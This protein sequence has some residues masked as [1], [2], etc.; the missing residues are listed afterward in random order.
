MHPSD[1]PDIRAKEL[2]TVIALAEYGSFVAAAAYLKTSQPALTRTIKR[3]E[4]VLGVTLFARNTRRVE[5]TSAGR[6]FVAVAERILNDLQLTVRSMSEV[7]NE[8]RGKITI[9]TFS[10]FATHTMPDLVRQYRETR[11]SMEVRIREGRQSEIVEDVRTGVA[12]FG[13]GYVNTLPDILQSDMLRREPLYAVIPLSHPMGAKRRPRVRL[14]ELRDEALVSPPSETYL[15]RLIDGAAAAAG[16]S[17]R[18]SVTVERLLSVINHVRA[19]VGIGILP[20]G[21][22]PH[23]PWVGIH[24]AILVEPSLSVSVGLIT[25]RGR[26]LTPAASS[27]MALISGE[28]GGA[29]KT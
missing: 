1:V 29:A 6:E 5:I 25:S 15:R 2:L 18:Y 20:A 27:M 10:A 17:P 13:I 4:R 9:S 21:V 14:A 8:Q 22:L 19:G 28:I 12:D 24:A 11:P 26:Y 23:Q 3:V 7:T 16:F